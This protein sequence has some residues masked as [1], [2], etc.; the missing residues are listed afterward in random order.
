MSGIL[1]EHFDKYLLQPALQHIGMDSPEA[2][3]M[4][5]GTAAQES[6][7]SHYLAQYPKGPALSAYQVERATFNDIMNSYLSHRPQLMAKVNGLVLQAM[8]GMNFQAMGTQPLFASA[9]AR[10]QWK[11]FPEPMPDVTDFRGQAILW[12]RR[13]NTVRGAGTTEEFML[14]LEHS[15]VERYVRSW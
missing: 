8:N 9:I 7:M 2:R 6:S 12:K 13:W 15:G 10:I 11:R 3:A 5:L 1:P 4:M 14:N